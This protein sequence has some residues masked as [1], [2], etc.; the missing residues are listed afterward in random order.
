[1]MLMT[2]AIELLRYLPPWE[3]IELDFSGVVLLPPVPVKLSERKS[4]IASVISIITRSRRP[5]NP[6]RFVPMVVGLAQ[7]SVT[8]GIGTMPSFSNC[9]S[10]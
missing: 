4:S 2:L 5:R 9:W 8:F 10:S 6:A 1:M 7:R 3:Q